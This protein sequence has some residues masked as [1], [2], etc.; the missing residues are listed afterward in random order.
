MRNITQRFKME[1]GVN[2]N[3]QNNQNNLE[4]IKEIQKRLIQL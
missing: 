2:L 4:K 3:N 1:Y